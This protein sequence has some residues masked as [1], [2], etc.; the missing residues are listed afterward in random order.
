MGNVGLIARIGEA[1]AGSGEMR[2]VDTARH[3]VGVVVLPLLDLPQAV[4]A[5][6]H[7]VGTGHQ[8]AFHVDQSHWRTA[9]RRKLVHAVEDRHVAFQMVGE[10]QAH[11]RQVPQQQLR[12]AP[13]QQHL[14]QQLTLGLGNL[15]FAQT[16]GQSR[17]D[18]FNARCRLRVIQ[19][20]RSAVFSQVFKHRLFKKITS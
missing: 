12:V 15:F 11:G 14:V 9:E 5:G 19:T 13:R 6:K 1:I 16:V 2:D 4:A 7:H 10:R 17:H 18:D 3:R 20:W 8:L